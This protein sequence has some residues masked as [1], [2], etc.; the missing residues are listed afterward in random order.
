MLTPVPPPVEGLRDLVRIGSGGFG[1]VYQAEDEEHARTVAVKLLAA[2]VA[3]G[4]AG[5]A[6]DR[7]RRAMGM[8]SSHPN[9]VVVYRSG[10]TIDAR[11]YIVMDYLAG[12]SLADRLRTGPVPWAEAATIGVKIAGALATAHALNI[13]HRDVKPANILITS[14]GEPKLGDF[15]IA[16]IAG[17]T[18]TSGATSASLAHAAPEVLDGK[19]ATFA[20]DVY[21]LASTLYELM[22]GTA[23]FVRPSDDS[24]VPIIAR[25][26]TQK[27]PD[28][29]I[30]GVPSTLASTL[31]RAMD[32]D[33][34]IRPSADAFGIELA[35]L[36]RHSGHDVPAVVTSLEGQA[37]RPSTVQPDDPRWDAAQRHGPLPAAGD[38]ASP[39]AAGEALPVADGV[40]AAVPGGRGL[41]GRWVAVS[42]VVGLVI[43]IAVGVVT[44]GGPDEQP[45]GASSTAGASAPAGDPL[46]EGM[47]P[48]TVELAFRGS[49]DSGFRVGLLPGLGEEP[50]F[51]T[52]LGELGRPAL[53]PHGD[54]MVAAQDGSLIVIDIIDGDVTRLVETGARDPAWSPDGTTVAYAGDVGGQLDLFVVRIDDPGNPLRVT[55]TPANEGSPAWSPDG[56]LLAHD[57]D[58]SGDFDIWLAQVDGS[59]SLQLTSGPADDETPA[60][61]P[62]G[63]QVAFVR[64][65]PGAKGGLWAVSTNGDGAAQ[66]ATENDDEE[67]GPA[68][69]PDGSMLAFSSDAD[70]D[71]DL[72]LLDIASGEVSLLL[73]GPGL[74]VDPD[75]RRRP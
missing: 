31:E 11:P 70:G 9:I 36:L 67:S 17:A 1:T 54:R 14:W 52:D 18:A 75:W 71:T 28:L 25:I 58:V 56:Q 27:P 35:S 44:R 20:S 16:R 57:T 23:P 6:F 32:K 29:R 43:L 33:P 5:G 65:S 39:L 4:E 38:D 15:G 19:R 8:L 50:R 55:D 66:P 3:I 73:G 62:S 51:L 2:P 34:L 45:T 60:Y 72:Y 74:Q 30:L 48:S 26:L 42:V 12:G 53:S 63:T 49:T 40:E 59:G 68:Y 7:E 21:S 46:A 69:S 10:M 24:V 61:H 13:I 41:T 22:A 64:R 37:L 47:L